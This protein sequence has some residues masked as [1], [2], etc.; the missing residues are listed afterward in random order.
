LEAREA[1]SSQLKG[2]EEPEKQ[3]ISLAEFAEFAEKKKARE[4]HSS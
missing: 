2:G 3:E 4:A 1:H